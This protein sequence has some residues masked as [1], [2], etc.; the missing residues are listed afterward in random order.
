MMERALNRSSDNLLSPTDSPV[1]I[2]QPGQTFE[3]VW[4][5]DS[6]L[7]QT[8]DPISPNFVIDNLAFHLRAC[9]PPQ[10]S[11]FF[12]VR[13]ILAEQPPAPKT[14][15]FT[16][17]VVN[18]NP[19]KN[20]VKRSSKAFS[21]INAY[22]TFSVM[23]SRLLTEAEGF[24]KDGALTIVL[25]YSPSSLRQRERA[26]VKAMTPSHS[27]SMVFNQ[28]GAPV[29][30][31][32]AS[33]CGLRNQG[34][35]CYLN[36][37]LQFLF[38]VPA[39]RRIV[40]SMPTTGAEDIASSI[41]LC[42][43]RLFC[44]MQ[45]GTS[46]CS[47]Q[48][49]TRSFGWKKNEVYQ[50]QDIQEFCR[51]LIANLEDKLKPTELAGHISGL[52][53]GK[54]ETTIKCKNV[55]VS[56][57]IYEEFHD[58]PICVKGFKS[59]EESLEDEIAPQKLE[60]QEQYQTE[61][62]G[63]QDAEMTS[64][65]AAFPPVLM[66]Q[67][68]R[69]EHDG[70]AQRN[71]KVNDRFEF[72]TEIDL[73]KFMTPAAAQTRQNLYELY[74]VLVHSGSIASGHYYAFLRPTLERKWYK[75]DDTIVSEVTEK[76]AVEENFGGKNEKGV[77]KAYSA[78]MLVYVRKE[79]APSLYEP[80]P[81][82][83]IPIHIREGTM[84]AQTDAP[85]L[86]HVVP[87]DSIDIRLNSENSIRINAMKWT[88]GF[89]NRDT[90]VVLRISG[91]ET[92]K[93]LYE[94]VSE[95]M[96]KPI[97]ELRIWQCGSYSVPVTPLPITDQEIGNVWPT[98]TSIFAQAIE[99]GENVEIAPDEK[100]VFLKFFFAQSL[101]TAGITYIGARKLKADQPVE[102]LIPYVNQKVHLPIDTD[103]LV[104][105]ETMQ[106]SAQLVDVETTVNTGSILIFQISPGIEC[107]N[108]KLDDFEQP[109]MSAI[110]KSNSGILATPSN[111]PHVSYYD[112]S[113]D[114]SPTTVD[115]FM[116]YKLRT[117]EAVLYEVS[118]PEKPVASIRFPSNLVWTAL[119]SLIAFA[120]QVNYDPEK[121]SIRLYKRDPQTGG[122]SKVAIS[123][124]FAPSM[125][126]ALSGS[127][128]ARGERYQLFYTFHPGIPEAM[129]K[130]MTNYNVEYCEDGFRVN[131]KARILAKKNSTF[132]QI[133]FE[134]QNRGLM[135]QSDSYRV[136]VIVDHRIVDIYE[137]FDIEFT[138]YDA[139]LRF[140]LVPQEQRGMDEDDDLL[141]RV[142]R[143]FIDAN[144]KPRYILDPFVFVAKG[145][146]KVSDLVTELIIWAEIP[147]E[148]RDL[149]IVMKM[150]SDRT[151]DK[152]TGS[153]TVSDVIKT[154]GLFIWEPKLEKLKIPV[155]KRTVTFAR[156]TKTSSP[157]RV[158]TSV[159]IFN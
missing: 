4:V 113:P 154:G 40:Y 157:R 132:R 98:N 81:D 141:L 23:S 33:Y 101:T 99:P 66:I 112:L 48:D 138:K 2:S 8:A 9:R 116:D 60:G 84:A 55:D 120:V 3:Y 11:K 129:I 13:V 25:R 102:D 88:T 89:D 83:Y 134:M 150:T 82:E 54:W 145:S 123:T 68:R 35:T 140:E 27:S 139:T 49:L 152:L 108:P 58:L 85:D 34:A 133:A 87:P 71:C 32:Q 91:D 109:P 149:A 5:I 26:L 30:P 126:A 104:F 128:P 75:F 12:V 125:R 24:L 124:K 43:Q 110:S 38:S 153:E 16:L 90:A 158:E 6:W 86:D 78:Y 61:E 76:E 10:L 39:F 70:Q 121:D 156:P 148:E 143:G 137:D 64:L 127:T 7:D 142:S 93:A 144:D 18:T 57:V 107:E 14:F 97:N 77:D 130:S 36:S 117:L 56:Q 155:L 42:L 103:L 72:P 44:R 106:H 28:P 15:S 119:K 136:V 94:K 151:A 37:L 63:K 79:D 65:F 100:V 17:C 115:Q 62:F 146:K 95:L 69:F 159:K 105:Q 51:V 92:V 21:H 131:Y 52:F 31:V 29:L 147:P 74:G 96:H 53:L 80:V 73:T 20:V 50:P 114:L 122:P 19:E 67:L 118:E 45:I 22:E 111:L 135:P 41:P 59:L 46:A 47:T 1:I